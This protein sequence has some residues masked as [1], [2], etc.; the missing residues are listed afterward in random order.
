M[1]VHVFSMNIRI[2]LLPQQIAQIAIAFIAVCVCPYIS[3][4][5]PLNLPQLETAKILP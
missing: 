4:M 2:L 1:H 3:A 5:H